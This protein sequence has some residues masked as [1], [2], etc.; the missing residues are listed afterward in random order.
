[1]T[2]DRITTIN[3]EGVRM[4]AAPSAEDVVNM[5]FTDII[6]EDYRFLLEVGW[7]LLA[8]EDVVPLKLRRFN[9]DVFDAEL[10]VRPLDDENHRVFLEVRDISKYVR[11]AQALR[12]REERLQNILHSVAEGIV[13]IAEDGRIETCNSAAEL[14]FHAPQR[15]LNGKNIATLI[16]ALDGGDGDHPTPDAIFASP[17]S[18]KEASGMREDGTTFSL[19]FVCNELRHGRQKLYTAIL[20]DISE[21]KENEERIRKLAH[22]DSLTGL[23]NRNLLHDR[24]AQAL[25]RVRR[26]GG[27][28]AILFVDL[29]K[30]KPINDKYGH[31]VGDLV[32]VEVARRLLESVRNSDTVARLGG[33]EFAVILEEVARPAEAA[34]VAAK[35]VNLLAAPIEALGQVC[36]IG[37]SVGVALYPDDGAD[38]DEVV[39][40]ADLAMYRV[41]NAGRNGYRMYSELTDTFEENADA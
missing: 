30:F 39:K 25:A 41:K 40:A 22:H 11:S 24:M 28:L 1:L 8:E 6:A 36:N 3:P 21:R 37:A 7:G 31:K 26:H 33:D 18:V 15:G 23:P 17:G 5:P 13:T 2:D 32:L 4:L 20:R 27:R 10:R 19:E 12:E 34:K 35:I 38:L 14:M 9:G 29:D 16:R